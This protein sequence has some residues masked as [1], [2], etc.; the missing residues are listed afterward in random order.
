MISK[1]AMMILAFPILQS[2]GNPAMAEVEIRPEMGG[3]AV[4]LP[5]AHPRAIADSSKIAPED[6]IRHEA[7]GEEATPPSGAIFDAMAV[8][9]VDRYARMLGSV[10]EREARRRL[11]DIAAGATLFDYA[12]PE[13]F[14]TAVRFSE[15]IFDVA[16]AP[17][18]KPETS[19]EQG[20]VA[21]LMGFLGTRE[22]MRLL[23][24][25]SGDQIGAMAALVAAMQGDAPGAQIPYAAG[26]SLSGVPELSEAALD[27]VDINDLLSKP[28]RDAPSVRD[29]GDGSNLLLDGW[30]AEIDPE[31]GVVISNPAIMASEMVVEPGMIIGPFGMVEAIEERD[32]IL[33]VKLESGDEIKS[34]EAVSIA[35]AVPELTEVEEIGESAEI[36]LSDVPDFIRAAKPPASD[37]APV[38]SLRPKSRPVPGVATE[39]SES[40]QVD[41]VTKI[42]MIRPRARPDSI[43]E[44]ASGAKAPVAAIRPHA[45]PDWISNASADLGRDIPASTSAPRY[46]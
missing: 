19:S 21:D 14:D 22:G 3:P 46:Q 18:A 36:I 27:S 24:T 44:K 10:D 31:R 4:R 38:T 39:A 11:E 41:P 37:F 45:R 35:A 43:A 34:L 26:A 15:T 1:R 32:G 23:S 6:V 12:R 20:S 16:E 17:V 33:V 25:M 28:D 42:G 30:I 40:A 5:A 8:E 2:L 7:I 13:G 29:V 9:M